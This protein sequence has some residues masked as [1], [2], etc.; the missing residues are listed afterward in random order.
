MDTLGKRIRF[1][2]KHN[3]MT[4]QDF[5]KV[6]RISQDHISL[7]E[8]DKRTPKLST[9][10]LI[11][12]HFGVNNEW[13]N[14]GTGEIFKDPFKDL[15]GP[16]KLKE[17]GRKIMSLPEEEYNKIITVISALLDK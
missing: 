13:L 4:Q 10:D 6:L 14:Y 12:I 7:Y 16:E 9:L 8:L 11:C 3:K 15:D 17:L 5:G 1:I 2:R